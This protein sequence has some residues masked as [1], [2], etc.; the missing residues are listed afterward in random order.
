MFSQSHLTIHVIP[1]TNVDDLIEMSRDVH[2]GRISPA[3][4]G[5]DA[6]DAAILKLASLGDESIEYG[7]QVLSRAEAA[8]YPHQ[9]EIVSIPLAVEVPISI[10]EFY[11]YTVEHYELADDTPFEELLFQS[12][13]EGEL[14]GFNEARLL[15]E[16]HS[17]RS[18][19]DEILRRG[20]VMTAFQNWDQRH[21]QADGPHETSPRRP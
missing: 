17:P 14:I 15:A 12:I 4:F 13:R 7:V 21:P 10:Y 6:I 8:Q 11:R 16:W 5:R 3:L 18:Q 1:Q 9:D 20:V 2:D 19:H